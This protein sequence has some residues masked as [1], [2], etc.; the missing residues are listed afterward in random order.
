MNVL[1]VAVVFLLLV[2]LAWPTI[3]QLVHGIRADV[4]GGRSE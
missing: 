4:G 1:I 2:V 3:V